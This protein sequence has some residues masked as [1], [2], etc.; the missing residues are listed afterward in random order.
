MKFDV[1]VGNPPYQ[2]TTGATTGKSLWPKFV[3]T[4]INIIKELG[5]VA[6]IHPSGWRSGKTT[7]K[8]IHNTIQA[9]QMC[10]LVLSN[11]EKGQKLFN[12]MTT[13]DWYIL[14]KTPAA[15]GTTI[16]DCDNNLHELFLGNVKQLPDVLIPDYQHIIDITMEDTIEILFNYINDTQKEHIQ[17]Y[18]DD[19]YKFPVIYTLKKAGPSYVWSSRN[20]LGHYNIPKVIL[21]RGLGMPILDLNGDYSMCEFS[22]AI[23][24]KDIKY[25]QNVYNALITERCINDLKKL[26]CGKGHNYLR[27]VVRLLRPEFYKNYI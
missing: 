23:V 2:E 15:H 21:G 24:G 9:Y 8:K 19:V 6:L 3:D 16:I 25:L 13:C 11:Y 7:A 12:V 27:E 20:D 26:G 5:Y 10:H 14:Q 4:S 17:K 22:Y 18:Q 1:I